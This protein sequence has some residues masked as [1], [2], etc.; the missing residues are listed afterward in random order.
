MTIYTFSTDG[1]TPEGRRSGL[2][3]HLVRD[4]I[5]REWSVAKPGASE[6]FGWYPVTE[7]VD[8]GDSAKTITHNG[9]NFTETWTF[10]QARQ[11]SRIAEEARQVK[12]TAV[13]NAVAT[14]RQWADDA[15]GITVTAGNIINVVQTMA[16]RQAIRDA[17]LADLIE[18]K[19]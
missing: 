16:D 1:T 7:V 9:S 3:L 5:T 12:A 8:P 15:A 2:P 14:L 13:D 11:D 6:A 19:L 17:R 4:L 10:E 18:S